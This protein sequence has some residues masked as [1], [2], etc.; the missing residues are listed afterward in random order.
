MRNV[1]NMRTLDRE[2][3]VKDFK[4][5]FGSNYIVERVFIPTAQQIKDGISLIQPV[6]EREI[7]EHKA[8]WC[9]QCTHSTFHSFTGYN[10][11]ANENLE[12]P[13]VAQYR[14][15]ICDTVKDVWLTGLISVD[16]D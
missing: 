9:G 1:I 10:H 5:D 11:P 12:I 8:I 4:N 13:L 16:I 3:A 15:N 14:C 2:Q 6:F 7:R